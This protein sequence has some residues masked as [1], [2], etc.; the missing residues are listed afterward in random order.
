[1]IAVIIEE[2]L[3]DLF[4]SARWQEH[5]STLSRAL[6]FSLGVYSRDGRP[7]MPQPGPSP[8]CAPLIA[9]KGFPFEC[10]ST[11]LR[12]ALDVLVSREP[13]CYPCN[14][15][16]MNIALPLS[17]LDDTAVILGQGSFASYEDYR[18]YLEMLRTYAP[19]AS[20]PVD[21]TL[22]FTTESDAKSAC[23]I[24]DRSVSLLLRNSEETVSLR[25]KVTNL[26]GLV[27]SWWSLGGADAEQAREN[28]V[29][30][31]LS[32]IDIKEAAI[33]A[34]DRERNRYVTTHRAGTAG[35]NGP[36]RELERDHH[37]VRSLL[38]DQPY[39][40]TAELAVR[41]ELVER[42]DVV[43]QYYFPVWVRRG[44]ENILLVHNG[45]LMESDL[46]TLASLCRQVGLAIENGQLQSDLS[47]KF[48][49]IEA[50]AELS[51]E[52]SSINCY[53]SL[54]RSILD[55]SAKLL[56]AEQGSLMLLDQESDAL[57]LK[58]RMGSAGAGAETVRIL[59]GEGIAGRVAQEGQ[60]I[61]VEDVESDPRIRQKNR[62]HYKTP[63]F[64]SVPLKVG[65]R[66]IGVLN[67]ADKATGGAFDRD[68]LNLLQSFAI[69][70]AVVLER[71]TL[72][73]QTEHLKKL[74]ISDPLTGLLNR[75]YFQERLEEEVA[76]S[77]RHDRAMSLLMID[78]DGFKRF[79]D[80]CGH[81]AGDSVLRFVGETLLRLVRHMDIV[82]RFGGDEFVV[83]LPETDTALAAQI[84][85]R[86]RQE[87]ASLWPYLAEERAIS[88]EG[89]A[90][91]IGITSYR[92]RS[93][94]AELLLD[95][96]DQALYR[97]KARGRN[98]V[99]VY[100]GSP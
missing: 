2:R 51:K 22:R 74:S 80:T 24:I 91:S 72:A 90:V 12:R 68:D 36:P 89:T 11:C 13:R 92:H 18:S 73:S 48:A 63:S 37:I 70:A 86:I 95:R 32:V 10:A 44:L 97:A 26:K 78:V 40:V 94:S 28:L 3:Q 5:F 34:F 21:T 38:N 49:R 45:L 30:N 25:K 81:L 8:F 46:Q 17:Y 57:L 56:M 69:H 29:R 4:A 65:A 53:E 84:A 31:L 20:F 60:A 93:D 99:E 71:N 87:I 47:Q 1:M 27:S 19:D 39:V 50:V 58:A 75:R 42:S 23:Q 96:A 64:L 98:R 15:R 100:A 41:K 54:L 83:I 67:L 88:C 55:H 9:A 82:A 61:V 66:T 33:L 85:E 59:K 16:V 62:D 14:A 77:Q 43:T 6:G 7:L 79:N 52:I 76:R 35:A